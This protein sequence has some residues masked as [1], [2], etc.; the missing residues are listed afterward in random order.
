MRR[1]KHSGYVAFS[2]TEAERERLSRLAERFGFATL[3]ALGAD[4]F[5]IGLTTM[6][7]CYR[8]VTAYERFVRLR[9]RVRR[10]RGEWET[11]E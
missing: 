8:P 4:L 10:R 6:D 2:V 3:D 1:V 5:R 7:A 9:M 11:S